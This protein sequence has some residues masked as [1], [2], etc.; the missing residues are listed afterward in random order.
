MMVD[1]VCLV[2]MNS[3]VLLL[4]CRILEEINRICLE[5]LKTCMIVPKKELA[6]YIRIMTVLKYSVVIHM[7]F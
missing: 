5:I 2:Q 7:A 3:A 1:K 6:V 4:M